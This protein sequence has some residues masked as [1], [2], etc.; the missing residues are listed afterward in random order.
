MAN[1]P[2]NIG[3]QAQYYGVSEK[4]IKNYRA[5]GAP[6]HSVEEMVNW[7]KDRRVAAG[8]LVKL[9]AL[10]H[11]E[12]PPGDKKEDPDWE[13]FSR[14]TATDDPKEAM[15]KIAK[16]RDYAAFKFERAA[17]IADKPN[18]KFYAELLA[19]MES[20]LHDAQ[21]RQRKL[22]LDE[23]EL[24]R[25]PELERILFA[26]AFWTLRSTDLHLDALTSQLEKIAPGLPKE[27]TRRLLEGEL[28]SDRFLVPFARAAGQQSGVS[29]PAWIVT[30]LRTVCGDYL[31]KGEALFDEEMAKAKS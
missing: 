14:Q 4:T 11:T 18:E 8:L 16:A 3:G 22:G 27:Q 21:L 24:I 2:K 1:P 10:T 29:V 6:L 17:K 26:L 25:R 28:L 15:A 12:E 30:K 13:A 31:A 5:V 20:T 23:G 7:V 19:K 9:R